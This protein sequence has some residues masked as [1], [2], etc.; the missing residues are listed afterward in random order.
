MLITLHRICN[1][2]MYFTE[3]CKTLFCAYRGR[4]IARNLCAQLNLQSLENMKGKATRI[5]L[6]KFLGRVM[7]LP[8]YAN[9]AFILDPLS[10]Y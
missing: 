9:L 8:S 7:A 4:S 5:K 2:L 10:C 3:A 1:L 6:L